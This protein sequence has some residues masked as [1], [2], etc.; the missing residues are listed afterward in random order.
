MFLISI[1]HDIF[2]FQQQQQQ[3]QQKPSKA[4]GQ[5]VQLEQTLP[6]GYYAFGKAA[7]NARPPKVR[8]PPYLPIS[9]ECPGK[10]IFFVK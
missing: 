10:Y 1:V 4:I 2:A 5:N 9:G 7:L 6:K 8:K 3:Q